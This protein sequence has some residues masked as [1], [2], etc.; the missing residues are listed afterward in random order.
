MIK[1]F[2]A[3]RGT[4]DILPDEIFLWQTI[5]TTSRH[6]LGLY[7]FR[8]IRTPIFEESNLF[9]RSLGQASDVVQKQMLNLAS[10]KL[11]ADA[12]EKES[13]LSLRPEATA[14]IVRSYIQNNF[15]KK[16]SLSKLYYIGAM[17]RG[18]RPQ[19]GRLRQFHQIGVEAI[20]PNSTTPY[21]DAEVI[22]LSIRLLQEFGITGFKLKINSLGSPE[23]K[24]NFSKVLRDLLKKEVSKLCEDCQQRFERNVFRIL[25]CKNEDCKRIVKGL[26]LN[27]SHLSKESQKYFLE[28]KGALKILNVSFE[29]SPYLV[30]GL[31]YYTHTVF[32][33]SHESLGSQD[34]L[35]AGGRYNGLVAELG[36]DEQGNI[37]AIGF[38]LG[39][40]RIILAKKEIE[41]RQSGGGV[42]PP[43]SIASLSADKAGGITP[44]LDVFIVSLDQPDENKAYITAFKLL[45]EIRLTG[46]SAE[47]A[48]TKASMKSQM[49]LADKLCAK[50][51]ILIGENELKENSVTLK[52]MKTG[53]QTK[54]SSNKISEILKQ[55]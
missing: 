11:E 48:Y 36:G 53:E 13:G 34:A 18:E 43:E 52:D 25:D 40:E 38:A 8:E 35:G 50:R 6:T 15:A 19:K 12:M 39:M 42:I 3:P 29:V 47:M 26:S 33:I 27:D 1:K 17:F 37:G 55:S 21:L 24:K 28:V 31:D 4:T 5:E 45:N 32:E 20:G 10:V 2:S 9:A 51:V 30:R 54:I 16:E 44:P 41:K 22:S 23:D 7:G 46:L 49:R 14:S